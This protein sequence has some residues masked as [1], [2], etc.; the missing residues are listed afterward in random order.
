V[1][2]RDAMPGG[3]KLLIETKTAHLEA[4]QLPPLPAGGYVQ[5]SV[6]DTGHGM[7]LGD[8]EPHF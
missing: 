7:S 2:A 3:G 6:S 4:G 1:N 5:L 8:R